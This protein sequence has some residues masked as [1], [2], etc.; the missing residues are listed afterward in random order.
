MLAVG[1]GDLNAFEQIVLAAPAVGMAHRLSLPRRS[2][3][4]RKTSPRRHFSKSSTLRSDTGLR[5]SSGL[6]C[7]VSSLASV[8]TRPQE[9]A[10]LRRGP[11]GCL[12][13]LSVASGRRGIT[14]T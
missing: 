7:T 12:R 4:V 6:T 5:P 14:G 9:A 13:A 10:C 3:D 2:G 1:G 11:F 8:W